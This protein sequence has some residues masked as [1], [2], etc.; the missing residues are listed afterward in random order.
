V[1]GLVEEELNMKWVVSGADS[2]TG[3][4]VAIQL[5]GDNESDV[6]ALA[7][8][9]GLLV[10]GITKLDERPS[11]WSL[12][13]TPLGAL[14]RARLKA[15]L[16]TEE[17]FGTTWESTRIAGL[18]LL[19]IIFWLVAVARIRDGNA[20]DLALTFL[21]G[22]ACF[23]QS[24]LLRLRASIRCSANVNSILTAPAMENGRGAESAAS[25]D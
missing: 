8:K 3:R 1:T 6:A 14:V 19:G 18:T 21:C 22:S 12:A 25:I 17:R 23:V 11:R 24:H 10:S 20:S 7:T 5:N 13:P 9:R 15:I 4:E 16:H 2:R